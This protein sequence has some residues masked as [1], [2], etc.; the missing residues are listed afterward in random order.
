MIAVWALVAFIV[1][2][3]TWNA[4]FKRNIGEAMIVGLAAGDRRRTDQDEHGGAER[5]GDAHTG[6]SGHDSRGQF[7]A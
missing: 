3:V 2:I 6:T 1:A 5:E 7:G 4:V